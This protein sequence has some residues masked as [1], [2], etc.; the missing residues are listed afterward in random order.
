MSPLLFKVSLLQVIFLPQ[1]LHSPFDDIVPREIK[2]KKEK[3]KEEAKK[4]Q[5]K[6]T[7]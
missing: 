4:S 7:K 3:S 1:V 6:A 2:A 5:S